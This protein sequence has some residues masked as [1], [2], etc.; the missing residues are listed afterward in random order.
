MGCRAPVHCGKAKRVGIAAWV[1]AVMTA[2]A[3]WVAA[4]MVLVVGSIFVPCCWFFSPSQLYRMSTVYYYGTGDG[5]PK[6]TCHA[7]CTFERAGGDGV[8]DIC[9][10]RNGLCVSHAL[11]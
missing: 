1:A 2:I 3:A 9:L 7:S 4:V 11:V 8:A 6:T 10:F 5:D